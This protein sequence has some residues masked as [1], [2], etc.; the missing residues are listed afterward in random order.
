M[1]QCEIKRGTKCARTSVEQLQSW[2]GRNAVIIAEQ[3]SEGNHSSEY[4]HNDKTKQGI[5]LNTVILFSIES[6]RNMY[7]LRLA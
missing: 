6:M 1:K 4:N 5:N 2:E 3:F 7:I